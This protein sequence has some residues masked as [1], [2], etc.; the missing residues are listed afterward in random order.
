MDSIATFPARIKR[1]EA[2]DLLIL[3]G[4]V[5]IESMGGKT[6]GFSGGR[7]DI[8]GPEEDI[9]WGVEDE[10]LE[11]QRYKGER[12]LDNRLSSSRSPL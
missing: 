8:W 4:N 1:S 9:L 2:S 10:W 11:N 6:Y 12:E 3:A 5:A 7:D